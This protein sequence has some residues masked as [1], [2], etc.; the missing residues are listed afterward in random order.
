MVIGVGG[1]CVSPGD[2]TEIG[3][4]ELLSHGVQ[5]VDDRTTITATQRTP[6]PVILLSM[7]G[8]ASELSI[9]TVTARPTTPCS[10]SSMPPDS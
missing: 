10:P 8:A 4:G 5:V 2:V 9:D 1:G 3:S 7:Q 6:G